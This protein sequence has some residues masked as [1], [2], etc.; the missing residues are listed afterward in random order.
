MD[1]VPVVV[2]VAAGAPAVVVRAGLA[3]LAAVGA[4][5]VG[6]TAVGATA[7]GATAVGATAVG[8][9]LAALAAVVVVVVFRGGPGVVGRGRR[10]P[11]GGVAVVAPGVGVELAGR[12]QKR[13]GAEFVS[14][15]P[16]DKDNGNKDRNDSTRSPVP[17]RSRHTCRW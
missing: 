7:V 4:T 16:R 14:E 8:A 1:P 17:R 10:R 12:L 13:R 9:G 2:T 6:A 3:P 5:A 11:V 15:R